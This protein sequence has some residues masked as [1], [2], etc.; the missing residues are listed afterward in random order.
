MVLNERY[1]ALVAK[2]DAFFSRVEARHGD[3]M[4]CH[5]GCNDCCQDGLSVT[6]VEAAVISAALA[7]MPAAE[8]QALAAG[9]RS[10]RPDRCVALTA[11][12]RCGIYPIRPLVCRSHGLPIRMTVPA[13]TPARLPVIDACF[14]NF[15]AGADR[16]DADCVLDQTTLS[17]VLHAIDADHAKQT[18]APA[19]KRVSIFQL[20]TDG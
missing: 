12:G 20:L 9:T 16:A 5:T 6:G 14:K 3:Q 10:P 7:A 2:V 15:T 1:A 4:Q 13:T 17:T 18:D 11:D 8:R 19:G